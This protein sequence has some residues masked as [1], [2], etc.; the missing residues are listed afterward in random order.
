MNGAHMHSDK[1]DIDEVTGLFFGAF[2]NRGGAPSDIERLYQLFLPECVIVGIGAGTAKVYD[3]AGFVE[4]RRA[5]LSEGTMTEFR[6]EEVSEKTTIFGNIAQRTSRYR[7]SWIAAGRPCAGSGV[8]SLQFVRMP[9]GW[10][11]AALA[12]EDDA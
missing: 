1:T 3:L 5:L 6:E 8:K 7:K 11:I 9:D 12:W 4:P 2:M 10:K